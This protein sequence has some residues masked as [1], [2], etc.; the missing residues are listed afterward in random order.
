M[1]AKIL[2]VDDDPDI[3]NG[4]KKRLH[5]L[6]HEVLT[7]TDGT[8]ALDQ[9]LK[10]A[11]DL[12]LLDLEMPRLSGL[13]VLKELAERQSLADGQ[14]QERGM[15]Q[16]KSPAVIVMTAFGTI[17]RAVEA[18]RLGAIDFLTKPFEVDQ[19]TVIID[20]ALKTLALSRRVEIMMTDADQRYS[21][22]VGKGSKMNAVLETTRQA[23]AS[24]V[25]VLVLGETG[26]GK[27]V[28]ARAIHRWSDRA[29]KPFMIVNCAALPEHLLEN[30]LFGHE[31]GAFTGAVRRDMG[32]I[33]AADGGT[34]FLDEIGD[35]PLGLQTRL[36]RVLQEQE[37]QRVGG[38]HNVRVN[39]RFVAA[40]NKDLRKKIQDGSFGEDLFFRLNVVPI[41]MPPLRE[42]REDISE[43][44]DY[45]V[46]SSSRMSNKRRA[47]LGKEARATL[48]TY[49]WPGNVRELE[50]VIARALVLCDG[51]LITEDHLGLPLADVVSPV[52]AGQFDSPGLRYHEAMK[53]YSC[54]VITDALRKTGWNQ[55]KAADIL[56]LQ[57][58]YLTKL[59]RRRGLSGR[60]PMPPTDCV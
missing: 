15:S 20:K 31:K 7:A 29:S 51:D 14:L 19:L 56:G 52:T 6:G 36:L 41:C 48:T 45:F 43:L 3:M 47:I 37:F 22:I 59:L 4:L 30:E 58:T 13:D 8:L 16:T 33:E 24:N 23:A 40:T 35:M 25:T 2:I 53:T 12:M 54:K 60:P 38:H 5:W 18:M 57:R 10:E 50:N 26:T 55:T 27:E 17:N 46:N 34:V 39:V 21:T 1:Q 9:T 49:D 32:K 42:R 44:A 11:P 28:I